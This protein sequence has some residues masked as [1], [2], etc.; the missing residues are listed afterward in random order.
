MQVKQLKA[1]VVVKKRNSDK[2]KPVVK[3]T[4]TPEQKKHVKHK[5]H[6]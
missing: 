1:A 5:Q 2:I 4:E 3:P 6:S